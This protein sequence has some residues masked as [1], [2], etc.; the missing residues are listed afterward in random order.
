MLYPERRYI[1]HPD[2]GL[3]RIWEEYSSGDDWWDVQVSYSSPMQLYSI[4]SISLNQTL[5]GN[6]TIILYLQIYLDSTHV[7][8]FG[9]IKYWSVF[10]WVGNV[11]KAD[12]NDRGGRGRA[13]LIAFLPTVSLADIFDA[14]YSYLIL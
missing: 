13:I 4:R 11:P 12:R 14:I 1:S 3:M 5:V 9:N 2:G 10:L 6:D 7:T 8:S